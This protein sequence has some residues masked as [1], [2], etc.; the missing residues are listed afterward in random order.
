MNR[1]ENFWEQVDRSGDCWI[2]QGRIQHDG[3]GAITR[4]G[5]QWL[6]HRLAWLIC[7]GPTDLC[8]LH[9]C[10][11]PPCVRPDHLFTGTQ[12]DNIADMVSK[13]RQHHPRGTRNPKAKLTLELAEEIRRKY[14]PNKNLVA[15]S[16][17]Y[18]VARSTIQR[19]ISHQNWIQEVSQ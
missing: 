10:D 6:A 5:R 12:Q 13:G 7:H 3:Y 4:E 8:V 16:K 15:L 1:L 11:N 2:W 9:K 14:I 19:V 18:G 17:E